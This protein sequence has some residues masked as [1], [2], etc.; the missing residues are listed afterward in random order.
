MDAVSNYLL[1]LTKIFTGASSTD[2]ETSE[3][4]TTFSWDRVDV[5]GYTV[6]LSSLPE[7][8]RGNIEVEMTARY[9]EIVAEEAK[10]DA[11]I[12]ANQDGDRREAIDKFCRGMQRQGVYVFPT[13]LGGFFPKSLSLA[14]IRTRN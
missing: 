4:S 10:Q 12:R 14:G 6:S 2:F 9:V 3:Y 7:D 1:A 11:R 8:V 5:F 13:D